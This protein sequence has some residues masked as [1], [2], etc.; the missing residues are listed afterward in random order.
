[1]K[2]LRDGVMFLFRSA[3]DGVGAALETVRA[4]EPAGLPPATWACTP[5]RW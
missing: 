5:A 1:M 2:F 4:V 3:T